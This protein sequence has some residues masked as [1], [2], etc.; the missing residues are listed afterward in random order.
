VEI[1]PVD[2][3][4]SSWDC[5]L[6]DIEGSPPALRL[7][8]RFIR[9]LGK[10]A[11]ENLKRAWLSGGRFISLED[12]CRR[13]GLRTKDLEKLAAAGAFETFCPGRRK[14]LWEVLRVTKV[15]E[16]RP[17]LQLL[18]IHLDGTQ[19]VAENLDPIPEMTNLDKTLAD[20]RTLGLSAGQ[21]PMTYYRSYLSKKEIK[22]CG[23]L[24]YADDGTNLTV[25][26]GVICRQRPG[27]AK[28]FVFITLEDETGMANIIIRPQLFEVYKQVILK[29]HFLAFEGRLQSSE[30][31]INL[32]A[33]K[34]VAL[35]P[36]SNEKSLH[37]YARNFH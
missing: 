16:E 35:P 17:L 11:E 4:K 28:G 25:A 27:T 14:A 24:Q 30:G 6:E 21:H 3:A 26:G 1:R 22:S 31:V 18:Q 19:Q 5:T 10:R 2:L 32:L 13:S 37:L 23:D 12:V 34:V 9:G 33:E 8:L 36:I 15:K 20:Y 7:G 29:N